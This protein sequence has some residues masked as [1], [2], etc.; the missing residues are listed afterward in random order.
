MP[1][2]CNESQ[3]DGSRR[4]AEAAAA[5]AAAASPATAARQ[6]PDL[7]LDRLDE[8]PACIVLAYLSAIR[9]NHVDMTVRL[10]LWVRH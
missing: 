3:C 9:Y 10:W 2:R 1:R 4:S 6:R 5:A 8:K 7:V